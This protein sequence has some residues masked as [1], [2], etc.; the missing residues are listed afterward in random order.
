MSNLAKIQITAELLQKCLGLPENI[1]VHRIG[2]HSEYI[3]DV[4]TV[5]L[6]SNIFPTLQEG[7]EAPNVD[8]ILTEQCECCGKPGKI[9]ID[10]TAVAHLYTSDDLVIK[11]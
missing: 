10:T 8:G 1:E 2:P 3:D 11:R 7:A 9:W 5:Y 6:K 4:F